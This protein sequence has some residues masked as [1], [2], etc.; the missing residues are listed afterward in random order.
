MGF[1]VHI[2]IASA[3]C[4]LQKLGKYKPDY[5]CSILQSISVYDGLKMNVTKVISAHALTSQNLHMSEKELN[6]VNFILNPSYD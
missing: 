1:I 2:A 5:F 6:L 4:M 3:S